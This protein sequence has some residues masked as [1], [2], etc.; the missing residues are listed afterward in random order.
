MVRKVFMIAR[1][2][3]KDT[4]VGFNLYDTYSYESRAI[5]YQQLFQA[6]KNGAKVENLD[7]VNNKIV[8]VG[9]SLSRYT[10]M[11]TNGN[12]LMSP[13]YVVVAKAETK[14]GT[15]YRITNHIGRSFSLMNYQI[16]ELTT[17]KLANAKIMRKGD[18]VSGYTYYISAIEGTID[19]ENIDRIQPIYRSAKKFKFGKIEFNDTRAIR[20]L[21]YSEFSYVSNCSAKAAATLK[22]KWIDKGNIFNKE[23]IVKTEYK[24]EKIKTAYAYNDIISAKMYNDTVRIGITGIKTGEDIYFALRSVAYWNTPYLFQDIIYIGGAWSSAVKDGRLRPRVTS[25]D[26]RII[27]LGLTGM[28]ILW[29]FSIEETKPLEDKCR[30]DIFNRIEKTDLNEICIPYDK[31][32][33]ITNLTK[34][35]VELGI[36][37]DILSKDDIDRILSAAKACP[38]D[39]TYDIDIEKVPTTQTNRISTTN[40]TNNAIISLSAIPC[41]NA[42]YM[43]VY[44]ASV[45][46]HLNEFV[47]KE[48]KISVFAQEYAMFNPLQTFRLLVRY[49]SIN[50]DDSENII[51]K[52]L[53]VYLRHVIYLQLCQDGKIDEVPSIWIKDDIREKILIGLIWRHVYKNNDKVLILYIADYKFEIDVQKALQ[54][55]KRD[56]EELNN[57]REAASKINIKMQMIGTSIKINDMG[58]IYQWS[59][60]SSIAQSSK[61]KGIE[62]T[63]DNRGY[64]LE[65]K[66]DGKINIRDSR[67]ESWRYVNIHLIYK[68]KDIDM[69]Q[70]KLKH[71]LISGMQYGIDCTNAKASD[72]S[73]MLAL[74]LQSKTECD[75]MLSGKKIK[76][77]KLEERLSLA[78]LIKNAAICW[79]RTT[80]SISF[81]ANDIDIINLNKMDINER[82]SVI[83]EALSG[84]NRKSN[85]GKL[86]SGK[87]IE[88]IIRM[89]C[90]GDEIR[91]VLDRFYIWR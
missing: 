84:Y 63:E 9:G 59:N 19:T 45:P 5:S 57:S 86:L 82:M 13:S 56:M 80:E 41:Q 8:G 79:S 12:I 81:S 28:I 25:K 65:V 64:K 21:E 72:I 39:Y 87:I 58:Y 2:Y 62:I 11:S 35:L 53:N 6:M 18:S 88:E 77:R 15:R 4:L 51:I 67:Q 68:P 76:P 16:N 54:M 44:S 27:G 47:A 1:I 70:D 83:K 50:I 29:P 49:N 52:P 85:R 73:A 34:K 60:D 42:D 7:I 10:A 75:I 74:I 31:I 91:D 61:I 33:N 43:T 26:S 89:M 66:V 55:W 22:Q 36:G 14:D 48:L 71:C 23:G 3:D 38:Y 20:E 78:F 30:Y 90:I 17:I 40:L 69:L 37:S 24:G 46:E 32:N